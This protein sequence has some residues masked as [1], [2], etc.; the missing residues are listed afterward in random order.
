MPSLLSISRPRHSRNRSRAA[1]SWAAHRLAIAASPRPAAS[2]VLS[3][4][5]VRRRARTRLRRAQALLRQEALVDHV[6]DIHRLLEPLQLVVHEGGE[7]LQAFH[8][9]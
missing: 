2:L 7:L 5:S 8:I 6:V 9:H 3:T 1:R 4:T